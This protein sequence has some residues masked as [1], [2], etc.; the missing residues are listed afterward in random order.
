M[1]LQKLTLEQICLHAGNVCL[2]RKE[3][4]TLGTPA[5]I[6]AAVD[7]TTGNL[8]VQLE[9]HILSL[10][11]ERLEIHRRWPANWIEAVKD[12]WLP[13]WLKRRWPVRYEYLDV[14]R[15]IYK[16]VCPHLKADP[17]QTHLHFLLKPEETE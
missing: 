13:R 4:A 2:S 7:I 16:A 6:D 1:P 5:E 15:T 12:R 17:Q 10:P 11:E 8:L 9:A 3:L 14:D